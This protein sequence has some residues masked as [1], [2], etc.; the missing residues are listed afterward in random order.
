LFAGVFAL[1]ISNGL[2]WA[3]GGGRDDDEDDDPTVQ[4][5]C[6]VVSGRFTAVSVPPPACTSPVGI[7]T[8]GELKGSLKGTYDLTVNALTPTNEP[9][10]PFVSFFSGTSDVRGRHHL[11]FR[12]T[13]TGALNASPPGV[14]GSGTFSTLLTVTEG[15]SGYLWIRGKLDFLTGNVRGRYVGQICDE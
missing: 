14:I 10:V 9:N 2:A 1:V 4:D 8:H 15:G 7:C 6:R 5:D 13:D 11:Q 3:H 12:G